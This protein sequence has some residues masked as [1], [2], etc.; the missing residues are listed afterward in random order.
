MRQPRVGPSHS[1][2]PHRQKSA[3]FLGTNNSAFPYE[4]KP[5]IF[6]G[7][8]I[9]KV[10]TVDLAISESQK[11]KRRLQITPEKLVVKNVGSK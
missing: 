1:R 2:R 7:T 11:T 9:F 3:G 6:C 10:P 4:S 8:D 5:Y